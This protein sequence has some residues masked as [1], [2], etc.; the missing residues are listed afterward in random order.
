MFIIPLVVQSIAQSI[1]VP[2]STLPM[3]VDA[4]ALGTAFGITACIINLCLTVVPLAIGAVITEKAG[5]GNEE[6]GYTYE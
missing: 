3:I 6:Y 1:P 5:P 4:N 2:S